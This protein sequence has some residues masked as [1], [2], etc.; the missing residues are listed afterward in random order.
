MLQFV[1]SVCDIKKKCVLQ[2]L[3][4]MYQYVYILDNMFTI[5]DVIWESPSHVAQ[6]NFTEIK[7]NYLKIAMFLFIF[8]YFDNNVGIREIKLN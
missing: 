8:I 7:Q 3:Y 1:V 5:C 4:N 6:G 2:I